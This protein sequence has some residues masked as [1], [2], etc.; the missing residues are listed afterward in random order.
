MKMVTF[1]KVWEINTCEDYENAMA[2]LEKA[3]FYAEMADDFRAWQNEKNEIARQM[4]EIKQ[5]AAEKGLV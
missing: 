3:N 1:G 4:A 2:V 5:Q